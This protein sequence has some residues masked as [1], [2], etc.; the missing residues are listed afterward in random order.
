MM[1][2]LRVSPRRHLLVPGRKEGTRSPRRKRG[3]V[4]APFLPGMNKNKPGGFFCRRVALDDS[5]EEDK[6]ARDSAR[7]SRVQE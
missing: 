7:P 4:A 2:D 6:T 5:G 1:G 3:Q